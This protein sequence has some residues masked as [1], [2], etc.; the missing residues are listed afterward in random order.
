MF[1]LITE[2]QRTFLG[3]AA[4]GVTSHGLSCGVCKYKAHKACVGNVLAGCKWST[5]ETV[6]QRFISL[7]NVSAQQC[8]LTATFASV[9]HI[10]TLLR[11]FLVCCLAERE[12]LSLVTQSR[13]DTNCMELRIYRPWLMAIVNVPGPATKRPPGNGE[14]LTYSPAVGCNW[15]CLAGVY[16]PSFSGGVVSLTAPVYHLLDLE[17]RDLYYQP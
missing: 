6:D 4:A 10:G 14:K 2:L 17:T 5:R 13:S 7:E 8:S 1:S 15:L 3:V 16:F 9:S 11:C 12:S